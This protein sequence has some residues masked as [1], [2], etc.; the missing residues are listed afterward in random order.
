MQKLTI[1][2]TYHEYL[3]EGIFILRQWIDHKSEISSGTKNRIAEINCRYSFLM[4]ANSIEAAANSLILSLKRDNNFYEEIER[5]GTLLKFQ[6]YCEVLGKGFDR[7]SVNYARLKELISCRNDFVHPKPRMVEYELKESFGVEYKIKRSSSRSYPSY[8]SE[9]N[10]EHAIF[11][12]QDTLN[13]M[14][15]I[16]FDTCGFDIRE[17]AF[18]LGFNS[19]GSSGDLDILEEELGL[20]FDKRSLGIG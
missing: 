12:L 6:I 20:M 11:A 2:S 17:G 18:K 16:C 19:F 8:F 3:L 15:W 14:S 10:S 13:F 4:F 1:I 7:S 9:I 5:L